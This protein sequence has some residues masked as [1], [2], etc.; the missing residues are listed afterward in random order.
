MELTET[1]HIDL[2]NISSEVSP[3]FAHVRFLG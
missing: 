1:P 3:S 2:E